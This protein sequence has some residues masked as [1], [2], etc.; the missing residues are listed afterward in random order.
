MSSMQL[1]MKLSWLDPCHLCAVFLSNM[2]ARS[3]CLPCLYVCLLSS[4]RHVCLSVTKRHKAH[5]KR[6][7]RRWTLGGV[8][9]RQQSRGE[10]RQ[11]LYPP[12]FLPPFVIVLLTASY[13]LFLITWLHSCLSTCAFL[14][15]LFIL[16][17]LPA[18]AFIMS[19]SPSQLTTN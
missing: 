3:S 2:C 17:C 11:M 18:N 14:Q 7:D 13:L 10:L 1:I 6:L 16:C 19:H 15:S 12:P 9:S 4:G 8:I 5:L